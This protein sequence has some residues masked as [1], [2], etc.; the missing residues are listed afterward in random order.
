[1]KAFI[2]APF[3]E[4][5][6]NFLK[7]LGVDYVYS[8]WHK[9]RKTLNDKE[10][11]EAINDYGAEIFVTELENV[12]DE[13]INKTDLKIIGICRNDPKRNVDVEAANKKGIPIIFTPG[14][15][16]NAVAE[17]TIALMLA[18]LR[19]IVYADRLLRSGKIIIDSFEDFSEFYNNLRGQE[20]L[21]KTVGIIGLGKI[22]YRVA[23]KLKAFG[24]RILVYDPYVSDERIK[25]VGGV[26]VDLDTLLKRSDIITIHVPPTEETF[27]LIGEKELEKMKKD[28]ILI[29]T[30][31]PVVVDE[32]AL[33]EALKAGKIAGAGLDVF[34]DEP[35]DSSNRFLKLDNVVVTPH[36]GGG[37]YE[38]IRLHSWMI[39][40]D[41][42][43]ILR[44]EKPKFIYN[45][46]VLKHV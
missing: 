23:R 37:T 14:R 30:A 45:P 44:G 33:Y 41:I 38:T 17:L 13:V 5:S 7:N 12:T 24:V 8:P 1:M 34:Y 22:G 6:L 2:T 3:S 18:V 20:L 35:V 28:A 36:I 40:S 39:V 46:E 9:T 25:S 26:R 16:A 15:N 10:I 4:D 31:S 29:N 42:E 21:G 43:R 19:K 11:I 27:D 32:D